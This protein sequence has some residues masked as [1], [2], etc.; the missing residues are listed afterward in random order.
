VKS[1]RKLSRLRQCGLLSG[2]AVV[3]LVISCNDSEPV[4]GAGGSSPDLPAPP[5]DSCRRFNVQHAA[6][7][8][9]SPCPPA[10]C[11]AATANG[12]LRG[13]EGIW[14]SVLGPGPCVSGFD[15]SLVADEQLFE[16]LSSRTCHDDLDCAG[17]RCVVDAGQVSGEC[18]NGFEGSRCRDDADCQ[19]SHCIAVTQAGKRACTNGGEFSLCNRDRDCVEGHCSLSAGSLVGACSGQTVREPCFGNLDCAAGLSCVVV[20]GAKLVD[21]PGLGRCTSGAQGEPCAVNQDCASKHC[22]ASNDAICVGGQI[23]DYCIA[24]ADC[25]SANCFTQANGGRVCANPA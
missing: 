13:L 3:A 11:D 14:C 25:D 18:G 17:G 6:E 20:T 7:A 9:P 8:C 2:W 23:G 22:L 16:C 1:E 4:T 15:C 19:S 10:P 21:L 12:L 5:D 24:P